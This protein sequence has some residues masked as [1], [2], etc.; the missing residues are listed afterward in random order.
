MFWGAQPSC[1]ILLYSGLIG[2]VLEYDTVCFANTAK[3]HMLGLKSV[4]YRELRN[5]LGLMGSTPNN[6]LSALSGI[7]PLAER[8]VYLN[9]RYLVAAFCRLGLPFREKLEVLGALNIGYCIGGY[10]DVLSLDIVPSKSFTR[11]ELPALL[12]TPLVDEHMEKK[13]AMRRCI[14]WWCPASY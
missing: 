6:C 5:A 13:L 14:H 3:T 7:P 4:Q 9:F 11:H 8:F 12:G 10:S 1:F 2:S